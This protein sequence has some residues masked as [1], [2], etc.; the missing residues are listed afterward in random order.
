VTE[1]RLLGGLDFE[2]T[3]RDGRPA[4]RAGLLGEANNGLVYIDEVNLL[5]PSL[6]HLMLDA[7]SSGRVAVERDGFSLVHPAR[8]ALLGS[9]NP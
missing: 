5:D 9:M 1:E 4:L 8:V 6:A 2:R 7:V 3:V